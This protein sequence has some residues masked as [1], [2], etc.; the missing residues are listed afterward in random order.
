MP[1]TVAVTDTDHDLALLQPQQVVD[2][3]PLA[4]SGL[5]SFSIGTQ[6]NMGVPGWLTGRIAP[7]NCRIPRREGR[8]EN[9]KR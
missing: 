5:Q 9:H 3:P 1:A 8:A 4:N 2:A 7:A 6:V